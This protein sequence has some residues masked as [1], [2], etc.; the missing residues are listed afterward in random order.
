MLRGGNARGQARETL[1]LFHVRTNA[2]RLNH[3]S[4]LSRRIY[5]DLGHGRSYGRFRLPTDTPNNTVI[6]LSLDHAA[7]VAINRA[8]GHWFSVGGSL[9]SFSNSGSDDEFLFGRT[10]GRGVQRLELFYREPGTG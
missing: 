8:R 6:R 3:N 10:A 5:R 4:G 2:A 9:L 7:V 1:G